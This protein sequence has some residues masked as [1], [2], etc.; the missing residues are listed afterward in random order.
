[1]VLHWDRPGIV[2][3]VAPMF[4]CSCSLQYLPLLRNPWFCDYLRSCDQQSTLAAQSTLLTALTAGWQHAQPSY[5]AHGSVHPLDLMCLDC[6]LPTTW[7]GAHE[8]RSLL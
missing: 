4:L 8:R 6:F 5:P 7:A 1:M 2:Q 3:L